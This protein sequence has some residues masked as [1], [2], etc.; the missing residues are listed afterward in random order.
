MCDRG[1]A[2]QARGAL[3]YAGTLL[4]AALLLDGCAGSLTV[5]RALIW[6][7]LATLFFAALLPA[8]TT[9]GKGWLAVRGLFGTH[10]VQTDLLTSVRVDG[11]VARRLVLRDAL[12][13]QAELP[14]DVLY[15][16]PLIWHELDA[17]ARLSRAA[18]L[19]TDTERADGGSVAVLD[20]LAATIDGRTTRELLHEAGLD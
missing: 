3:G 16:N 17:A 15:E 14:V 7:A 2:G 8:R 5:L 10:R 13:A 12:G 6:T 18:G 4:G 20:Q 11:R 19:F 1:W 9:A